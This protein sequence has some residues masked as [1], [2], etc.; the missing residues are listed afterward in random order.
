MSAVIGVR[1]GVLAVGLIALTSS[2]LG[3]DHA[4]DWSTI[5]GG[6]ITW[7]SGGLWTL[8]GTVGPAGCRRGD[9]RRS[10]H[11]AGGFWPGAVAEEPPLPGDVDG[12]GDVDLADLQLLLA[13]Y[14][15]FSGDPAYNADADFDAD[16][17]VD[18]ADLQFLLS[19]Y[20]AVP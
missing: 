7:S 18:L 4:I 8:G 19:N 15:T 12:D 11:A 1:V 14:G 3:A 13:A 10:V 2:G 17:D 6:G 9:E 5:D 20:G 16:G